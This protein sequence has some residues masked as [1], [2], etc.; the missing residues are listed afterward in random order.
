MQNAE[1]S[2]ESHGKDPRFL[3]HSAFIILHSAF[4]SLA[5]HLMHRVPAQP[6]AV[7]LDLDLL[8]A[9]GHLDLSAVV[10]VAGLGAL[11]PDHFAAFFCHNST[12][13]ICPIADEPAVAAQN[14]ITPA[15]SG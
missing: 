7:L 9:A 12:Y 15:R 11:Q 8:R 1:S 2:R 5:L 14:R 10:Q 4:P 13:R 6:G 3:R